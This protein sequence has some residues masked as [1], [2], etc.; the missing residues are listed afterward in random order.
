MKPIIE[1]SAHSINLSWDGLHAEIPKTG[2]C[3]AH[4]GC[5]QLH[6]IEN[7]PV[8]LKEYWDRKI[9]PAWRNK[10]DATGKLGLALREA[11]NASNLQGAVLWDTMRNGSDYWRPGKLLSQVAESLKPCEISYAREDMLCPPQALLGAFMADGSSMTFAQY[12]QRYSAYLHEEDRLSVAVAHVILNL[13]RRQLPVF[14]C[15]DP[16]VPAY[17]NKAESFS[18]VPYS[19][20][21]WEPRLREEG[22][23]R[24]VLTEEIGKQLLRCGVSVQVIEIDPSCQ[25]AHVHKFDAAVAL[26]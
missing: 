1:S 9:G 12:A 3:I 23:H 4:M 14:Y 20:R 13:A 5:K 16:Y 26:I 15:V 22:C 25:L 21:E 2:V 24:V 18:D 10:K 6:T 8:D 19:A 17:S 7:V 11:I